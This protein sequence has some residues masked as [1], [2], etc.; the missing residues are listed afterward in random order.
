MHEQSCCFANLNLLLFCRSRCRRRS[1]C[2]S[3]LKRP[4]WRREVKPSY[5]TTFIISHSFYSCK[6]PLV[7]RSEG[8]RKNSVAIFPSSLHMRPRARLN[9]TPQSSLTPETHKQRLGTSLRCLCTTLL[10]VFKEILN[11]NMELHI[12]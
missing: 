4:L 12:S 11:D 9:L 7:S 1:R 8:R 6:R 10:R 3:S 5:V 2:L